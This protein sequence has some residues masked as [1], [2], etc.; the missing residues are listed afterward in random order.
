[1]TNSLQPL[2]LNL[3]PNRYR[4][5]PFPWWIAAG[6]L[7]LAGLLVGLRPVYGAYGREFDRTQLARSEVNALQTTLA[8]SQVGLEELE[9][10]DQRI[11]AAQLQ[12]AQLEDQ[13]TFLS[14]QQ[15]SRT[16]GITAAVEALTW[17][18]NLTLHSVTLDLRRLTLAGSA[19]SQG[20]VL[21]YARALQDGGA[22]V[23]VQILSMN[24]QS[25][26]GA[27]PLVEFVI[28]AEQ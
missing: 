26:P 12:L 7:V 22:F 18:P 15:D 2:D 4:A 1:M 14:S 13:V 8:D 11:A 25:D 19:G 10:L 27:L 9:A 24:D 3:L 17:V 16:H 28:D 21:D 23:N 5:Q 6:V 20:L